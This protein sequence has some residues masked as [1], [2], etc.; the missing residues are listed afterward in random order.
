MQLLIIAGKL[1]RQKVDQPVWATFSLCI[2]FLL[3][4]TFFFFPL[5][6]WGTQWVAGGLWS[7]RLQCTGCRAM[8]SQ[9]SHFWQKLS[10]CRELC[11]FLSK[12]TE[13]FYLN[14][15]GLFQDVQQQRSRNGMKIDRL[16]CYTAFSQYQGKLKLSCRHLAVSVYLLGCV[17]IKSETCSTYRCIFYIQHCVCSL[18]KW[19]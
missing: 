14:G 12:C 19:Q 11:T 9:W 2:I 7:W 6:Q 4:C 16:T 8:M 10:E 15:S 17:L 18:Q 1:Q 13:I 5:F 3:L